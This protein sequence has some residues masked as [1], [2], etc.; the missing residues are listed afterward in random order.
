MIGAGP[1]PY[2][3]LLCFGLIGIAFM[4]GMMIAVR[5]NSKNIQTVTAVLYFQAFLVLQ[6][7]GF[8]HNWIHF[9]QGMILLIGGF[10]LPAAIFRKQILRDVLGAPNGEPVS[11]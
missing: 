2:G 4:T 11:Q 5:R 1:A 7:F 9:S 6:G 8:K 3:Y 10:C